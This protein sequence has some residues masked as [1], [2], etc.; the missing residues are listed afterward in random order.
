MLSEN[1]KIL[2]VDDHQVVLEGLKII[3]SEVPN[4]IVAADVTNAKEALA[5]LKKQKID[6][7]ITDIKMPEINGIELTKQIKILHPEIKVLILSMH[8]DREFIR[9]AINVEADGYLLKSSNRG[10]F[11]KAL[12]L[13]CNNST[14]YDNEI[15]SLLKEEKKREKLI[16]NTKEAL[17][18]REIEV[19][20]LICFE[21]SSDE[22]ADKLFVSRHSVDAYRKSIL[23][24][25]GVKNVIGIMRFAIQ[26]DLLGKEI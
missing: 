9:A 12:H 25:I 2:L 23:Q 24:K 13:I 22:I 6:I 26:H 5:I 14:Y 16:A 17:T 11:T 19:V 3:F 7:V 10:Q 4:C 20:K 8:K 15:I 18:H 21:Y 1:L